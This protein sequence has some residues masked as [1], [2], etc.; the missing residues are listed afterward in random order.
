MQLTRHT[1]YALRLL[2]HLASL[3]EGERVSIAD[4]A[5]AQDISRTHLMKI[6]NLLA[7]AGFIAA[8]RGRGGGIELALTPERINLGA[9]V[10]TTEPGTPLV[11]CRGCHLLP[12]CKLPG[13]LKQACTAFHGVLDRYTLADLL[14]EKCGEG[15]GTVLTVLS[16][17]ETA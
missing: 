1:D 13:I 16:M 3:A 15:A 17:T 7:H 5:A 12:L 8:A 14:R 9:V 6:A 10:R 11:D 4:V 2:I